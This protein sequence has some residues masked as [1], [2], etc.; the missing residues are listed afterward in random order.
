MIH[1][2]AFRGDHEIGIVERRRDGI[3]LGNAD[4]EIDAVFF[5]RF[6]EGL[7]FFAAGQDGRVIIA[8][9]VAA[10]FFRAA[11]HG[12]SEGHAVGIAGNEKLRKYDELRAVSG[13]LFNEGERF[14][15]AGAFVEK[16]RRGLHD[17]D[18]AGGL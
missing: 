17:G 12:E 15:Q 5:C 13:G 8:L 4:G 7:R 1:D 10:A 18:G 3:A 2:D 16:D 9:P 6:R 14:R 11:P